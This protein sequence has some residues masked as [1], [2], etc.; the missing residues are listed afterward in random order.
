[1]TD[2]KNDFKSHISKQFDAELEDL[3]SVFLEMG[4]LVEK[5]IADGI[6]SLLDGNISQAEAVIDKDAEVN[7]FERYLDENIERILA[8]RQ[9]TAID[10]RLIIMLSKSITDLERMGDEAVKIAR[11]AKQMY[12]DGESPRGYRETRNIGNQVRLMIHEALDSFARFDAD[13]ALTVMHADGDI[14]AE[15]QSTI[16]ALLTYIMEDSR[17]VS[18]IINVMWVLRA[19]ERIG[20]HARNIAEQ[21]IYIVSGDD[22]RH[23]SLDDVEEKIYNKEYSPK[24]D[25]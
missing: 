14:D 21:V 10:L 1:M 12:E 15:Y 11:I 19:I 23:T 16:R 25:E 24:P 3:R 17:F 2:I 22:V 8:R 13:Q 6:H 9:P 20:D 18:R 5:Q 4:G 7:N